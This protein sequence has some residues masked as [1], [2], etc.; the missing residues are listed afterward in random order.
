ML[1]A[2]LNGGRVRTVAARVPLTPSELAA[3]AMACRD[4]GAET[5]HVHPRNAMGTESLA[6]GDVAAALAAIRAA[7][8][9]MPVGISTGTWIAPGG[10]ARHEDMAGWTALPDY[11]SINLN[12]DDA[13]EI[14]AMMAGRGIGIEAGIWSVADAERFTALPDL[15]PPLR[16]LIEMQ[17]VE[18]QTALDEADRVLRI[19]ANRSIAAPILLHGSGRSAWPCVNEAARRRCDTRIGYEDV[20]VLPDDSPAGDNAA[21]VRAAHAIMIRAVP[22]L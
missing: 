4:A 7:V 12:E 16:I 19:L 3:D 13:P 22:P 1:Q 6:P 11:V 10:R 2:C 15:P 21:L 5:L 17:D 9:H 8:P 18:P 20:L 14:M